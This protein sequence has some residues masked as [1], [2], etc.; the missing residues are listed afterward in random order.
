MYMKYKFKMSDL[1][2]INNNKQ[3]FFSYKYWLSSYIK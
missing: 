2:Y 3:Q 1:Y